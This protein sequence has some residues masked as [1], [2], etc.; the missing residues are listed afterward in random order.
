MKNISIDNL[1]IISSIINSKCDKRCNYEIKHSQTTASIYIRFYND[2]SEVNLRIS[3]HYGK[4]RIKTILVK[5]SLS[6][7][8]LERTVEN[9]IKSLKYQSLR[10]ILNCIGN[11]SN[12]ATA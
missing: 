12:L 10:N 6:N 7:I 4:S 1:E 9:C 11:K 5:K 3:D 8:V 2:I